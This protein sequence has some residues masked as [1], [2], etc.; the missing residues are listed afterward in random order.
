MKGK[1][2]AS[3]L[4]SGFFAEKN[5]S[6]INH[7]IA[8]DGIQRLTIQCYEPMEEYELSKIR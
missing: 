7:T 8:P 2:L 5:I 4:S 3:L 6:Y 1:V